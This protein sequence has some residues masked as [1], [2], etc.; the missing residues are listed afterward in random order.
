MEECIRVLADIPSLKIANT[1]P[2]A[3]FCFSAGRR[4]LLTPYDR[5][6]RQKVTL[7]VRTS[8]KRAAGAAL[9]SGSGVFIVIRFA[10]LLLL[11]KPQPRLLNG[12]L[13]QIKQT[14]CQVLIPCLTEAKHEIRRNTSTD[15]VVR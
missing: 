14:P 2:D 9:D 1:V 13:L 12:R 4:P 10:V 5:V 11:F 15:R 7:Y 3:T 8:K 6:L